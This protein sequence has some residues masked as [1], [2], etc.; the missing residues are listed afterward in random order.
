MDPLSPEKDLRD[1]LNQPGPGGGGKPSRWPWLVALLMVAL[2]LALVWNYWGQGP[3]QV[4]PNTQPPERAA[5]PS[6]RPGAPG[7]A[8]QGGVSAPSGPPAPPAP[9]EGKVVE[10]SPQ[11]GTAQGQSAEQAERKKPYGLDRSLDAVVR[12]DE[13][14]KVGDT[15]VAVGELERKLV[16]GQRGE[17]LEKPLGEKKR[18]SVWGVHLVRPGEN[19]W[20][21][22]YRLLR[23]YMK[24][25][26]VDLP[27]D[28]D[29]PDPQGYSSGVGKILK[30]AEHMVGVYNLKT[31]KMSANLDL[32]EPG[33]KVV[34]FNLSEIFRELAKIDPHDLS[35]VMYDGRVLLFPAARKSPAKN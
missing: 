17:I 7:G 22:H 30:F 20:Q 15:V 6:S 33:G 26:G 8:E 28:A 31:G 29:K 16:V 35:G 4:A 19:L 2:A 34:V 10:M 27:P 5:V 14:I 9:V 18:V 23:E 24:S 3:A 32:L 12:S 11:G 21:I 25:R 1:S 13:S